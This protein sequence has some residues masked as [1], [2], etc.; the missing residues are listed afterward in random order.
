ML[1]GLA[2]G[3]SGIA[4][5]NGLW[6]FNSFDACLAIGGVFYVLSAR[7]AI[8]AVFCAVATAILFGRWRRCSALGLPA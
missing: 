6:G 1:T 8:L 7:S 5:Y 2:L 4:I 3:A